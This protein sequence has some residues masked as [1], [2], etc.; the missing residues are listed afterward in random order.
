MPNR[1]ARRNGQAAEK[2]ATI[3]IPCG[4][5]TYVLRFGDFS[6]LDEFD[7]YKATSAGGTMPGQTL[8][9]VFTGN[10]ASSFAIAGLLWLY[11]RRAEKGLTFE[12]VMR[13]F[14]MSDL[15]DIV[16]DDGSDDEDD[17]ESESVEES[18]VVAS[19]PEA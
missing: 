13:E 6:A 11:R 5:H 7:Y 3:T 18:E 17:D 10:Q 4:G 14:K 9:D 16:V 19:D 2:E 15:G 8:V 1:A 12:Q